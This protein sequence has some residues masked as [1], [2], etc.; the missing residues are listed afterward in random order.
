MT[1]ERQPAPLS[2]RLNWLMGGALG[3]EEEWV[4]TSPGEAPLK[5]GL[6]GDIREQAPGEP[7]WGEACSG[8][9]QGREWRL[10]TR[11]PGLTLALRTSSVD[12]SQCPG[13]CTPSSSSSMRQHGFNLHFGFK[14][15]EA[16]EALL[17]AVALSL[18]GALE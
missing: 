11:F 18:G 13:S 1:G 17:E 4:R 12:N 3:E 8:Q 5:E 10:Q 14:A 15:N 16:A 9:G 6:A 7:S 2:T